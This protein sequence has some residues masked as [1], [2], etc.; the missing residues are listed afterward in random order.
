MA[1]IASECAA[2]QG[3]FEAFHDLLYAEQTSIGL[4]RYTEFAA[5]AGVVDTVA[6]GRCLSD[7]AIRTRLDEDRAAADRLG[8]RGTPTVL[9][10]SQRFAGGRPADWIANLVRTELAAA[11]R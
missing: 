11:G 1:A 3:R 5:R 7:P 10:N 9:V 4:V 2:V 6:F 8:V